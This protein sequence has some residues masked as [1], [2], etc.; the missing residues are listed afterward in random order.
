[1]VTEWFGAFMT[2]GPDDVHQ[3]LASTAT[4]LSILAFL[5]VWNLRR[6]LRLISFAVISSMFGGALVFLYVYVSA[7]QLFAHSTLLYIGPLTYSLGAAL[8]FSAV[9]ALAVQDFLSDLR[10]KRSSSAISI[11]TKG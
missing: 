5:F 4:I 10:M 11:P 8:L 2:P 6:A 7:A 9:V 1:M 3:V